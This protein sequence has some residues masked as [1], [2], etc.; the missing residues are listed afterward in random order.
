MRLALI[1][2]G[3]QLNATKKMWDMNAKCLVVPQ[4]CAP[5]KID[6]EMLNYYA[7]KLIWFLAESEVVRQFGDLDFFNA[8]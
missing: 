3:E 8:F 6:P 7:Q 4:L 2:L 5:G 1:R